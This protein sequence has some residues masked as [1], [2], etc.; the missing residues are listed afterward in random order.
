MTPA[1]RMIRSGLQATIQD[2]GRIGF[3]RLGMP[4]SGA[5]DPVALTAANILAGNPPA[6]AGL[7]ILYVSPVFEV[8]AESVRIAAAGGRGVIEILGD[9]NER[10]SSLQSVRLVRDQQF[11]ITPFSGSSVAYLSVEGG[12]QLTPFLGSCSTYQRASIGGFEGRPVEAGDLLPLNNNSA[13]PREEQMLPAL[14][15]TAPG[16]FRVVMGPQDDYFTRDA[17]HTFLSSEFVVSQDADRMGMRLDGPLLEHAGGYNIVSDGI[18]TGA[19]QVPGNRQPIV[20][21]ADRQTTGGYPKIATVISADWPAL[22]RLGPGAKLSF[23]SISVKEA[24][25]A[26][27]KYEN[28]LARLPDTLFGVK[29]ASEMDETK[30]LEVNLVSGVVDAYATPQ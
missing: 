24:Q 8:A 11:R 6:T 27:L 23:E 1:L 13:A 7:E 18:T 26:R 5:L 9:R 15:L 4:V 29:Q 14:D 3:Q 17:I 30:L 28:M 12:F 25:D 16:R 2:F 22:G 21:R 10:V 20:L 19:I